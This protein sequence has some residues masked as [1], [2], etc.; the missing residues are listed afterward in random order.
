MCQ[1]LAVLGQLG[2][3]RRAR[4]GKCRIIVALPTTAA[5]HWQAAHR[6][7]FRPALT[8]MRDYLSIGNRRK[9]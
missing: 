5:E 4:P 9:P 1:A 8:V 3:R 6:Q 7:H 2:E